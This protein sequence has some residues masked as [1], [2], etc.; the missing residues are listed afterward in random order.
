[1]KYEISH[2]LQW[3][4]KHFTQHH[5]KPSSPHHAHNEKG[6]FPYDQKVGYKCNVTPQGLKYGKDLT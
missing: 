2:L 1:M 3:P 4:Q 6:G 5:V